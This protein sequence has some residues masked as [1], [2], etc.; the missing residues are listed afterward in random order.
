MLSAQLC[1]CACRLRYAEQRLQLVMQLSQSTQPQPGVHGTVKLPSPASMTGA[2]AAASVA[3]SQSVPVLQLELQRLAED[4]A[5]L[6][7][8]MQV[9]VTLTAAGAMYLSWVALAVSHAHCCSCTCPDAAQEQLQHVVCLEH[10]IT[11]GMQLMLL[12]AD[13]EHKPQQQRLVIVY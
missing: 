9:C 12:S 11:P 5:A 1:V 10:R 7:Q 13:F 3:G 4:R 2:R 6:M 8:K